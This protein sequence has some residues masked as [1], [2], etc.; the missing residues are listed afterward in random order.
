MSW[1]MTRKPTGERSI[2]STQRSTSA[3]PPCRANTAE[4]RAEPTK[5]QHTMAVVLA[6]RNVDSFRLRRSSSEVG[7]RRRPGPTVPASV[8]PM[9]AE[10]SR[11]MG[12]APRHHP[13]PAPATAPARDHHP[14]SRG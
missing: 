10:T 8:P 4:N 9:A 11:A 1:D 14:T 3:W 12:E 2:A 6:V 5:S 7:S 13:S